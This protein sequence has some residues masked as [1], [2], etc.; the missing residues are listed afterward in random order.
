MLKEKRRELSA[1][2][3]V[4]RTS[5]NYNE[6]G[7][8]YEQFKLKYSC[9]HLLILVVEKHIRGRRHTRLLAGLKEWPIPWKSTGA[10]DKF[11][12]KLIKKLSL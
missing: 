4:Q 9:K 1:P 7:K 8:A 12:Q 5:G 2:N 3:N 11:I 6:H 10:C